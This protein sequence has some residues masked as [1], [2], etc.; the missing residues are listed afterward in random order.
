MTDN[1]KLAHA[2]LSASGAERWMACPGSVRLSEG[3]PNETSSF[4]FEGTC[5]H[6]LADVVLNSDEHT[7]TFIGNV[8]ELDDHDKSKGFGEDFEVTEEMAEYVGMYV[9]YVRALPG[10]HFVEVRVDLTRW[11]KESFGT[12]DHIAFDTSDGTLYVTDLKYGKGIK[13]YA[14]DNPQAMLYGLGSYDDLSWMGEVKKVVMTIHQPRLDHVDTHTISIA[15][16]LEFG[17]EAKVASDETEKPDSKLVAGE[18]QCKFCP[19]RQSAFGCSVYE[20]YVEDQAISGFADVSDSGDITIHTE[21]EDM[22]T[23]KIAGILASEKLLTDYLSNL[24]ARAFKLCEQGD[25]PAGLKVVK[26]RKPN[27]SWKESDEVI[28]RKLKQ[29]KGVKAADVQ[30]IKPISPTK[31][32]KLLG[33]EDHL[34]IKRNVDFHV[35]E[36]KLTLVSS[37]DKRPA[38]NFEAE[39]LKGFD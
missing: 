37:E 9:D 31:A 12:S 21:V 33:S 11:V 27:K 26:G 24:R 8:I 14:K 3:I 15:K 18:T 30:V 38:H 35:G 13:K 19:V 22:K 39:A 17:E 34:T 4:A 28:L 6:K 20:S 36:E 25:A 5:A 2:I 1:T 10:D 7:S 29:I 16:L 23:S 32:I